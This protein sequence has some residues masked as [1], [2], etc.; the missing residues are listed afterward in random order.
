[1]RL[2]FL[3]DVVGRS[4]REVI[5]NSLPLLKEKLSYDCVVV[6]CE[7]AAHGFGVSAAICKDFFNKG[8]AVLTSG[9]HIFDQKETLSF[10][11]QEKRLLR[12]L[13]YPKSTPGQGY[14]FIDLN[15]GKKALIIN[16]MGRLFM[17]TLDDPFAA[18]DELL[19]L[20]PLGGLIG[21]IF[22]DFHAETSAEKMAFA[23]YFD[24]RVSAVVGTHTHI[25]TADAQILPKGTAYQTDAG[26]CGDYN[27]VIGME[28][29]APVHR[30]T[31]KTP[32]E[33]L[34]PALGEATLCGVVIE[35]D[36]NTGKSA[37][38]SP[39]RLGG[40]LQQTAF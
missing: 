10:I 32:S 36:T 24:G 2:L 4:G 30:F 27:S 26:M 29:S 20:Y 16:V 23:H 25:P 5:L 39:I 8:V 6:N 11:S 38:I 14:Y 31:K 21:A 9:N 17:E 18:V 19:K 15:N 13:N 1:M 7:N 37:S 28:S 34:Q 33:R 35:I 3:G 40:R 12:P 22:I